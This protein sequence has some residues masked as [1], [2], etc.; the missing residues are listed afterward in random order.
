MSGG[1]WARGRFSLIFFGLILLGMPGAAGLDSGNE[2]TRWYISNRAGLPLRSILPLRRDE[3]SWTLRVQ[4]ED[5]VRRETLY[6]EEEV[7]QEK[8]LTLSSQGTVEREETRRQGDLTHSL[9]RDAAGRIIRETFYQAGSPREARRYHYREGRLFCMERWEGRAEGDPEDVLL[10]ERT[11][12]GR[13]RRLTS[14]GEGVDWSWG[15][16]EDRLFWESRSREESLTA[17]RLDSYGRIT[18][19]I[20]AGGEKTDGDREK[21]G[22]GT[23]VEEERLYREGGLAEVRRRNPETGETE[24]V[25]YNPEG[26]VVRR[27]IKGEDSVQEFFYRWD[28]DQL[29]YRRSIKG[30]EREEWY[31]SYSPAGEQERIQYYRNGQLRS[32]TV[33]P[34]EESRRQI[35]YR[36]DRPVLRVHYRGGVLR[37]EERLGPEGEVLQRR[38][39]PQEGGVKQ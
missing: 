31:Y 26:R 14:R 18:A 24:V 37:S 20:A 19:G 4:Q 23:A 8:K 38:E 16:A 3:F 36:E 7:F 29:L 15:W 22:E 33:F 21:E 12:E 25:E 35:L 30:Y 1:V 13:L 9:R 28:G 2:E 10:Y 11:G 39:F 34:D 6:R 32:E 5:G 17:Y 27:I